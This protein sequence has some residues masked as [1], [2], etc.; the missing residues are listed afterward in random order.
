ML[1]VI[2]AIVELLE[3]ETRNAV[4]KKGLCIAAPGCFRPVNRAVAA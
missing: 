4:E 2:A 3:I 1:A